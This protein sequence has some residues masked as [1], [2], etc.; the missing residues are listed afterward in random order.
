[1]VARLR[2]FIESEMRSCSMDLVGITP[3][4]VQHIWGG[5]VGLEDIEWAWPFCRGSIIVDFGWTVVFFFLAGV[6][7]EVVLYL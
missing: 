5:T 1:M 4:Y 2:E 7:F 3:E 6:E